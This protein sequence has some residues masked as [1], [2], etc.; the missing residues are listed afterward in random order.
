MFCKYNF[1]NIN[2]SFKK[3]KFFSYNLLKNTN[4]VFEI[5]IYLNFIFNKSSFILRKIFFYIIN[6]FKLKFSFCYSNLIIHSFLISKGGYYKRSNY[7]SKGKLDFFKKDFCNI[8]LF[9]FN[10]EKN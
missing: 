7:R 5:L 10:G 1:K 9:I 3:F 8:T 6:D 4:Y 2:I